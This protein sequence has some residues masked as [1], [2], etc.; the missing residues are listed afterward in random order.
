MN[1]EEKT[2]IETEEEKGTNEDSNDGI[3]GEEKEINERE[4]P[5]EE[6]KK[7]L[8]ETRKENDR[9]EKLLAEEKKLEA[10]RMVT[11]RGRVVKQEKDPLQD[12]IEYANAV[13][14][15]EVDPFA[16]PK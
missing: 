8:E 3:S 6:A 1:E 5:I 14:K 13:N 12:P 9:R 11:G 10:E 4:N 16:E 15:G 2:E 7:V